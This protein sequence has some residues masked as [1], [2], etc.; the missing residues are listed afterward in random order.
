MSAEK[1]ALLIKQGVIDAKTGKRIERC[2]TCGQVRGDTSA[3]AVAQL[4]A[5]KVTATPGAPAGEGD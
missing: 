1:R 5:V 3:D 4:E 2:P